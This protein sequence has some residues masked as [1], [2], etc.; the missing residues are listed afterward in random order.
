L[1]S[2]LAGLSVFRVGSRRIDVYVVGKTPSD[3]WAGLHTLSV[4]T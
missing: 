3:T 1:E 4:E 2:H